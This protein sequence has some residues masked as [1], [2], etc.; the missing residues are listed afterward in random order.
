ML[1]QW[2]YLKGE[3]REAVKNSLFLF[4]LIIF[5][6]LG[7]KCHCVKGILSEGR[8]WG[9]IKICLRKRM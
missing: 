1:T 7:S 4:P 3:A 9:I 8:V 5:L 6:N 2:Y